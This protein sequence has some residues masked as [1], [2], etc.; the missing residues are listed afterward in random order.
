MSVTST[1]SDDNK[2]LTMNINGR[3]DVSSYDEFS[4]SYHKV[5]GQDLTYVIDMEETD[6]VDSSALGMMLLLRE[7]AG[8]ED[9]DISIVNANSEIKKILAVANFH[10]MF[11]VE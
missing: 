8:G 4:A 5:E 2:T 11:K 9:A 1:L 6:Y 10:H 3:F 7:R